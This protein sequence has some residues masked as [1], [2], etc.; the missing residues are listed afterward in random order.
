M[1]DIDFKCPHC[2]KQYSDVDGKYLDRINKNKCGYARSE[3]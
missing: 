3:M 2:S 1:A